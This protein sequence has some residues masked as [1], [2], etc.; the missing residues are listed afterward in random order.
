MKQLAGA[1][2]C[3]MTAFSA[4]GV[5]G[6]V[7]PPH[8]GGL[9]ESL[10]QPGPWDVHAGMGIGTDFGGTEGVTAHARLGV[11]R[12]VG[13]PI[14]PVLALG[15]EGYVGIEG[16]NVDWGVRPQVRS[17]YF[18]VA[19]GVDYN[20]PDDRVDPLISLAHPI[21]RGGVFGY[22]GHVRV[23]YVPGRDHTVSM[24]IEIP[25]GRRMP[26]G[27][28]RPRHDGVRL[29][30]GGPRPAPYRPA[31][32]SLE[33]A[34]ARVEDAALWIGRLVV[35]SFDQSSWEREAAVAA[36][37]NDVTAIER[38]LAERS[39]LHP[40]G[41][42]VEGDIRVYHDEVERAFSIAV[43]D[44]SLAPGESTPEGRVVAE[45]A[46][47]ILLAD[48]L[49]PYD[50]LLGQRKE[51]DTV[52]G[53]GQDARGIFV[54]WLHT[55]APVGPDRVEAALGVFVR[56]VDAVEEVRRDTRARWSD[57]R[58]VWLPLQ[59]ALRPEQH[60]SQ[61]ELDAL[62][63]RAVR[64]PFADGNDVSYLVNEQFHHELAW[65]IHD[66]EDYHVLWIHDIRGFDA[67]GEPDG[68]AY[69][70]VLHSYLGALIRKVR[71][72]DETGKLPVYMIFLDQWFYEIREGRLWMELL[73]D[74]MGHR[75]DLPE[76]FEQWEREIA[77]AQE[78]L[79]EAVAESRLLQAEAAQFG[80]GWL[81]NRVK[82]HVSITNR[83]DLSFWSQEVMPIWGLPDNVMRDHR[84]ISFYDI[85]EED[86]YRGAVIYTGMGVGEHYTSLRWEDRSIRIQG[87]AALTVK[88]AA[89]ELLLM[90]GIPEERIPY[91]LQPRP[92]PSGFDR[93]ETGTASLMARAMEVHNETGYGTKD[94]NVVK[95]ILYSLMP[96]GS[97]IKAPDSLWNSPFWAALLTGASF[98]GSR[99]LVI[100]P[101]ARN[102]PSADF[103]QLSR[104][105]EVLV[106]LIVVQ[107]RL[108]DEIEAAGGMLKTGLY[109]TDIEVT[110]I[111]AKVA[112]VLAALERHAFLRELYDF[113]PSVFD[114]ADEVQVR[115]ADQNDRWERGMLFDDDG[116]PK[117]H[118]KGNFFASREAWEALMSRPEWGEYLSS[119]VGRRVTQIRNRGQGI[120]FTGTHSRPRLEVALP[121]ITDW[122]EELHPEAEGKCVFYLVLGSANQ[123][124]RSMVMDGEAAVLLSGWTSVMGLIDFI[125]I[126]GLTTWV[127]D[128]EGLEA[129]LPEHGPW[130]RRIGQ[131]IRVAL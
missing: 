70:Q 86:P 110:D 47:E 55:E 42:T 16:S 31:D 109:A 116:V 100:A 2:L 96:A 118:L 91:H 17:P 3:A 34:L 102:A 89:R 115:L 43:S 63:E 81:R 123:N 57:S 131:W 122:R 68:V 76:G 126:T 130:K 18:R 117:L 99:V 51:E 69:A 7:R 121:L 39:A 20:G 19:I 29:E 37:V 21:R 113:D 52:L 12:T 128:L 9:T 75:I 106:R 73:E 83:S 59:L 48:V 108:A 13:N 41:R 71:A 38:R 93:R 5:P 4:A 79:R 50:R 77:A 44:R 6:Q 40:N 114:A 58:F 30:A 45:R 49:L 67:L 60:D 26:M 10:G 88:D 25:V 129:L 1:M 72:Y 61:A 56:L 46:R 62:L 98:R 8:E 125:S 54:R 120:Q 74:P 36:F 111:E 64:R 33:D 65:M 24:G 92:L 104:S 95:A 107:Q 112:A 101:A 119:F 14:V 32:P 66:A 82:V 105:Q 84:K 80:R 22:G 94:V 23:D 11:D 124:S 103:P 35:P 15:L 87:P 85:T 53:F 127:D 90:Q 78:E 97:V 28:T 27:R